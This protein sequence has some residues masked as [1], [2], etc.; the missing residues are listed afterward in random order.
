[1]PNEKEEENP[2]KQEDLDFF[3]DCVVPENI[4]ER[5]INTARDIKAER[6]ERRKNP[7]K[8]DNPA[9]ETP[10]KDEKNDQP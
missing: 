2:K 7:Q 4:K 1:M 5:R 8:I 6:A 9:E 10:Q 3:K